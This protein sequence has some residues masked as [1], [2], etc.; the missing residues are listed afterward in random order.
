MAGAYAASRPVAAEPVREKRPNIVV[1]MADDHGSWALGPYGC[2]DIH[3]PNLDALAESG[4]VFTNARTCTPVCSPSRMTYLTGLLPSSHG[5][6]D[7]LLPEDSTGPTSRQWLKGHLTY[8]ELLAQHGY[9]LGM[10]GKWHM[11]QDEVAQ[12]GFTDWS[13]MPG[14]GGSYRD[15]TFIRNGVKVPTKGFREDRVGDFALDFLEKQHDAKQPFYLA[16]NF[17]AP[18]TPYDYQPEEYRAPYANSGFSCFPRKPMSPT[19]NREL[20]SVYGKRESMLGYS[21]LVTAIDANVGRIVKKLEA[22]GVRENTLIVYTA[23]HGWNA[24]HH[25][26]WGKGNGSIPL[27]LYEESLRVPMIWNLPGTVRVQRCDRLIQNC[28][29]FP[30]ILSFANI[31]SPKNTRRVGLSYRWLLSPPTH[32]FHDVSARSTHFYEYAYMR[33]IHSFSNLK[34]IERAD[35]WPNELYDLN[36][37][38]REEQNVIDDPAYRE[39]RDSLKRELEL[40]F[41]RIGAP[42]ISEWRSTTKQKL[43]WESELRGDMKNAHV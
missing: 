7:Y 25:G 37:D 23:D 9:T 35:G 15:A 41:A 6:Q 10:C 19:E 28:D 14:G 17:Y 31:H 18:H 20:V 30:T 29:F 13:T 43:P 16:V 21:A 1:I 36:N 12:C 38:P 26:L 39:Q 27:N 33:G 22:M 2:R 24:G 5:V 34:Y 42:P 40:Y 32:Y 3:T 8:T 11:G 4:A